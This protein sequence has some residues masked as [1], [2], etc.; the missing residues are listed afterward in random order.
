MF[1]VIT[2][3]VNYYFLTECMCV[4]AVR[5]RSWLLRSAGSGGGGGGGGGGAGGSGGGG[6]GGSGGGGGGG[7]SGGGN[8]GGNKQAGSGRQLT[9]TRARIMRSNTAIR[10]SSNSGKY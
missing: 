8:S 2:H 10:G 5:P 7:S 4:C 1:R 6:G 9:R 3:K